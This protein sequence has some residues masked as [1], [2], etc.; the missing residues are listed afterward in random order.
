M[1]SNVVGTTNF[2]PMTLTK[3]KTNCELCALLYLVT[4]NFAS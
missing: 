3:F 2:I 4:D 1:E